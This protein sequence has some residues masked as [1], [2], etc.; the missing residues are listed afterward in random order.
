MSCIESADVASSAPM[1][2][3]M[4]LARLFWWRSF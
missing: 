4:T 1:I 3:A 2:D